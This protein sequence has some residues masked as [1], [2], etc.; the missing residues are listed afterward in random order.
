[1]LIETSWIIILILMF[2]VHQSTDATIV[3]KNVGTIDYISGIM[4]IN[5]INITGISKNKRWTI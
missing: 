4:T 5:P 2:Q 1:M 3:R